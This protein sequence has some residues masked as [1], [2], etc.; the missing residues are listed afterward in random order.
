MVNGKRAPL[1]PPT[2][3]QQAIV[4]AA[5][6]TRS[7]I[8]VLARAG[9]GK[10]TTLEMLS[11]EIK[12][13]GLA[14]AFNK[15]TKESLSSRLPGNFSV[16]TLNGLGYASMMRA[17]PAVTFTKPDERKLGRLVRQV[18]KDFKTE[19]SEEEWL[20]VRQLVTKV[21]QFGVVPKDEGERP[22]LADTPEAWRLAADELWIPEEEQEYL[23]ELAWE[24]L[25]RSNEE[26][27]KGI[28]SF[29]DQ[30]YYS[31]C[32]K[33][34]FPKFPV[35]LVDEFQDLNSLNLE[36]I[37]LALRPD[38]R[39]IVC[40]DDKQGVY[41]FRG[42]DSQALPKLRALRNDWIELPLETTW[43][44]PKVVV[45]RQQKW[46]PGFK[47]A[48]GAPEGRFVKFQRQFAEQDS[49]GWTWAELLELLPSPEASLAV[50][51]RNNSPL[52]KLAFRLLRGRIPV[53][54]AGRDIGQGL[55][56]LSKKLFSAEASRETMF[57]QLAEWE[58]TESSLAEA[59][60]QEEK[61]EGVH[62]RAES[63]RAVLSDGLVRDGRELKSALEELFNRSDGV[64]L[65]SI[66]RAKG[67][68]WDLVLH[69]DP[70][71]VPGARAKEA[72]LA[73]DPKP[74]EQER[75]LKYVCET[76]VKQVLVEGDLDGF[77]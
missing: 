56:A 47:A 30:V 19:L 25:R 23:I 33:G 39:L 68:E 65:S 64:L 10:T 45:A 75:N 71:R 58:L 8:M 14:V 63:L 70:W 72:E 46:V 67:L 12:V 66:H 42:A 51:C 53:H 7:S 49:P 17:M 29:D 9:T 2:E 1:P 13:P 54:M 24:S 31:V 77:R 18:A 60:G 22:L 59:N 21:Q 76:R 69:L 35:L 74:M 37:A 43:R 27:G 48:E 3:E 11:K 28:A 73:G 36:M 38:G 55:I 4:R 50:L 32:V 40:G 16:Q 20:Q 62:D 57:A 15:S 26:V 34:K 41:A 52:I 6:E 61:A 5:R 44:C